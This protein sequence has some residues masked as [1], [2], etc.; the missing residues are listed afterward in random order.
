MKAERFI[1]FE[2]TYFKFF[3]NRKIVLK[4]IFIELMQVTKIYKK[5]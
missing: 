5:Q 3:N 4:K 2:H 1:I